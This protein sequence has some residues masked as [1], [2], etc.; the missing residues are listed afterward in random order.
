MRREYRADINGLR[1]VAVLLVLFY[2]LEYHWASAG[3]LGV[4][5]F[6]V[7]SG[8]LISR[9]LM[10]D[11]AVGSFSFRIFYTRRF[12]RLFP[13]LFVTLALSV[14]AGYFTLTPSG[15]SQLGGS[16]IA[17]TFFYS[18]IFFLGETGYF[19]TEAVFKPLLHIWSLSLEEQFYFVW[20]L[21]LFI[22]FRYARKM[23]F[24]VT[25]IIAVVSIYISETQNTNSPERTFYLLQFRMFE[26]LLGA[27]CIW[28]EKLPLKRIVSEIFVGSG[29]IMIFFSAVVFTVRTPMPGILT[30]VPCGG[31]MLIIIAG[32]TKYTGF[33]L[34]NKLMEII[35]KTSYSVYLV[36]WPL[37]V[38][39]KFYTLNELSIYSQGFLGL[40]SLV[41]GFIMWKTVENTLR[42]FTREIKLDVIWL[43]TPVLMLGLYFSGHWII[44]NQG[45]PSRYD[46][47]FVM[48]EKQIAE[49][50]D[51]Y[52]I[53]S[54]SEK[55]V[56]RGN[57][58]SKIMVMGNSFAIDLIYAL[59]A[60]GLKADIIS[61]QTSHRC[62]NFSKTPVDRAD[63]KFCSEVY[64]NSMSDTNWQHVKAVYLFDHWPK[65]D[66]IA[67]DSM[68]SKIRTLTG[69]PVYVFGP[70]MVYKRPIPDIVRSCRSASA[71]AINKFSQDFAEK[72]DRSYINENLKEHFADP[73]WRQ[74]NF[75]YVDVLKVLGGDERQFDII[76]RKN[77]SFLYFDPSH[78][79]DQG[80]L[81]FGERL[82]LMYPELYD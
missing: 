7:I 16:V 58:N 3:F 12:K 30:L 70:K 15:F 49:S 68:L 50:R 19:D 18:N 28:I 10:D 81:E 65:L 71:P 74:R 5:I 72:H 66:L 11:M 75:W 20:P 17:G 27:L 64:A 24:P 43:A 77:S 37:I 54:S 21:I 79:T 73:R 25:F 46:D 26:F 44:I 36:H 63:S 13:A 9:N 60:N 62:F 42:G 41:L 61:L 4:D 6:L 53:K 57:G 22:V 40:A 1:A 8:Y 52:W 56:L 47:V 82:K 39:Y 78:F 67:L 45:Y 38:Y 29:L 59:R 14:I 35:G 48:T 2:H 80:A 51:R 32:G 31:A 69:A 23:V 55:D 76:S 33:V 34:R